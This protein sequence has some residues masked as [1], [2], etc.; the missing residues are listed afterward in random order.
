[1]YLNH[2]ETVVPVFTFNGGQT[3]LSGGTSPNNF[4]QFADFLL[5]L[6]FSRNAQAMTPL[7]SEE[8]AKSPDLPATVRSWNYGV[9]LR[10]QWQLNRKMT[11]SVGVRWE[12]YPFPNRADSDLE[13]FDFATNRIQMCGLAGANAQVCDIRVQKDLFTPRLGWAYRPTEDTVIRVGFSRNPQ[14]D[15]AVTRVGGIAQSFPKLI[16]I[17]QAAPNTF[18]SV[19]SISEGVPLV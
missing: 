4:N 15:N 14:S 6:P 7:L 13:I 9:Y 10:D 1:M 2:Y 11:A 5:G 17:T 16:A 8:G 12:Y 3:A 19:G 18:A